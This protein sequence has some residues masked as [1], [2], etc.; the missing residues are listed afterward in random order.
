MP[1][2]SRQPTP[3]SPRLAEQRGIRPDITAVIGDTPLVALDRVAEAV[4]PRVVAKM[5]SMNPGGSVKDRI[6]QTATKLVMSASDAICS[7][8]SGRSS[9]RARESSNENVT[10]CSR[11]AAKSALRS[12]DIS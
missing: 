11:Y 3:R 7:Q 2:L 6:A 5:D 1:S 12:A 9:K 8:I 10:S 4:V